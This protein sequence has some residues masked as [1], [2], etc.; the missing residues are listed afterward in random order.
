[1]DCTNMQ[2][3]KA[4]HSHDYHKILSGYCKQL[5]RLSELETKIVLHQSTHKVHIGNFDYPFRK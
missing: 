3:I 2:R 5:K 1:M 4:L